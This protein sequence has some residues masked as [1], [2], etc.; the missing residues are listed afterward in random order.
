P[1]FGEE[2]KCAYRLLTRLA[3]RTV[4]AGIAVLR[5]DLSGTGESTGSHADAD[6]ARWV[7]DLE[8]ARD[9]LLDGAGIRDW[10]VV[11]ARF[12][13]NLAARIP[14]P[15]VPHRLVLVEPLLSGEDGLR[16]LKR[17]QLIKAAVGGTQGDMSS[18]EAMEE[19]WKAGLSVDFGGF[20]IGPNLRTDMAGLDLASDLAGL[21]PDVCVSVLRVTGAKKLPPAWQALADALASRTESGV[22]IVRDKPF[23][24]QLDYYES[25]T[26]IDAILESLTGTGSAPPSRDGATEEAG[27]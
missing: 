20:P 9:V 5:L 14:A 11:G 2:R 15:G 17:R 8:A 27:T 16:D 10:N 12:G 13:A 3:R 22:R 18:E 7:A 4:E 21:P 1:P 19:A 25:D 26:V 23:W 6:V 24:G